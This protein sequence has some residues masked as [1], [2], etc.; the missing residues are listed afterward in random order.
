[1]PYWWYADAATGVE[2]L[3]VV[4]FRSLPNPYRESLCAIHSSAW[5]GNSSK[6]AKKVAKPSSY[7]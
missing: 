6:F 4:G 7:E 3:P 2:P 1:L 5:K